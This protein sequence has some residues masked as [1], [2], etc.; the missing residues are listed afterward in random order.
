MEAGKCNEP[1]L[2]LLYDEMGFPVRLTSKQARRF[3]IRLFAS[4]NQWE[5]RF[6]SADSALSAPRVELE[7]LVLSH[8][9]APT[10][11]SQLW[12]KIL[13]GLPGSSASADNYSSL[14]DRANALP[15][16]V[17]RQVDVDLPRTFADQR[18]FRAALVAAE[19]SQA[20]G[21]DMPV[22]W[23]SGVSIHHQ[24]RRV[25]GAYCV[26]HPSTGYLQSMNFIAGIC[27][28]LYNGD[29][30]ATFNVFQRL[31]LDLLRGYVI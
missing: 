24:L 6:P 20:A 9:M 18:D 15:L 13:S 5:S 23:T 3:K 21:G 26:A 28:L 11:R 4:A 16:E 7:N 14:V 27:L 10:L 1:P 8:G 30:Q 19:T 12:L 31:T 22:L 25:L 2:T 29:E 17:R